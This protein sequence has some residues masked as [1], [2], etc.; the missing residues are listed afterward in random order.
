MGKENIVSEA[1]KSRW[2]FAKV[3]VVMAVSFLVGLGLCGLDFVLGANGVGKRNW[4]F[5]VGPLDGISLVVMVLSAAGLVLSLILW[6]LVEIVR[7]MGSQNG[8]Q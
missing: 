4:E 1:P 2:S 3:V 6:G 5:Y 8:E 7:S